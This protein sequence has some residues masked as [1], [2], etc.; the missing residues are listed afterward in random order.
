[1]N[2]NNLRLYEGVLNSN[3]NFTMFFFF[4]P[5]LLVFYYYFRRLFLE[6]LNYNYGF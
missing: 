2:D 1:M 4:C 5:S 6:L 3:T